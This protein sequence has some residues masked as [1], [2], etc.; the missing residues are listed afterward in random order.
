MYTE[1]IIIILSHYLN[2]V[3]YLQDNENLVGGV[4]KTGFLLK[5]RHTL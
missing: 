5:A 3:G 2:L 4:P 1:N